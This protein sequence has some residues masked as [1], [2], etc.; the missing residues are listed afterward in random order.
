MKRLAAALVAV[1]ALS[2][3]AV[4]GQPAR[5]GTAATFAGDT[6]TT[7]QVAAWG[8]AQNDMGFAYDPGAVL[9]LLLL[10]PT[11]E[12]EAASEGIV[13]DDE[14][15][16]SEAQLWMAAA[17]ADV[18]VPTSDMMDVVRTVRDLQALVLTKEGAV[19]VQDALTAIQADATVNPAYGDFTYDRVVE[20][21]RAQAQAQQE[22][23][24]KYGDVSYLVFKDVTGFAPTAK[25]DWMVDAGLPSASPS[26]SPAQ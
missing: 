15:I 8:T 6:I 19:A 21:V 9:T 11:L 10:R 1:L 13:F 20:T 3:C 12:K 23:G 16:A 5:P 2:A 17:R 22:E 4:T 7:A 14:Q 18:V 26:P 24:I 25:R